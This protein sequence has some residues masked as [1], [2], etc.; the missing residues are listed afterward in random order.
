LAREARGI[1]QAELADKIGTSQVNINRWESGMFDINSEAFVQIAEVL[2]FPESF[3]FQEGEIAPPAFYRKRDKVAKKI[4]DVINANI[5]IYRLQIGNLLQAMQREEPAI[6][7]YGEITPQEAAQA[8]RKKWKIAKGAI[9]NMTDILEVNGIIVISFDFKTERVDSQSILTENKHPVIFTNK[10]LL[11][12]RL[13]F[14]LAYEL[15]HLVMHAYN[16]P[17]FD[18]DSGHK[19]NLF[20]AEFLMPAKD[21]LA[22]FKQNITLQTLANLKT[23]WKVSMQALL[24]RAADL[25]HLTPNQKR[26]LLS[27]FNDLSIR[28]REPLELDIAKERPKLLRDLI[29][30]YRIRQK[31]T[32]K[33]IAAYFRLREQEFAERYVNN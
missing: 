18:I 2:G 31:M 20:A 27:Q 14:S 17:N 5:N 3:F 23:K 19:A 28:R 12:D 10:K 30:K 25:E 13:R 9:E 16:R 6:P 1:S 33:D 4:L 29:T 21:I 24:Y 8:L 22:D 7:N 15:G 26:Y 32:I 11:G